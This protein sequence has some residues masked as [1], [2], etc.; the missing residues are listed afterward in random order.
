MMSDVLDETKAGEDG[1]GLVKL[2]PWLE[3][4]KEKLRNRY[5][6][7]LHMKSVLDEH[8]GPLGE[9]TLGHKYFGLNRGMHEGKSGVWY[10]EWAPL[11][12]SLR[13]IGDFNGWDRGATFLQPRSVG[14]VVGVFAG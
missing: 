10:R 8:G 14:R 5:L 12:Q 1:T 11:A 2:D 7:F 6:H 13:L 9:M 3:P 4:Y